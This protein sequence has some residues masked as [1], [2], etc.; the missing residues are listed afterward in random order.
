MKLFKCFNVCHGQSSD[1]HTSESP[2][3]NIQTDSHIYTVSSNYQESPTSRMQDFSTS[4]TPEGLPI[5]T[6]TFR[7]PRTP[8]PSETT[9]PKTVIIVN[10]DNTKCLGEQKRIKTTSTITPLMHLI[11][12]RLLTL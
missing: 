8:T 3:R 2:E 5:F 1:P 10:P 7:Q 9:S 12:Q 4:L 6:R 11:R